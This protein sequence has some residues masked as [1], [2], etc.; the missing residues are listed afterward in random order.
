MNR[1][2][3]LVGVTAL[4]LLPCLAPADANSGSSRTAHAPQAYIDYCA[5]CHGD[6]AKGL[7]DLGADLVTSAFVKRQTDAELTDFMKMGRHPDSPDST[8]KLLMPAFDYLTDE[9][10]AQIVAFMRG[11]K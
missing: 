1:T 2:T 6:D 7:K 8:M 11:L 10:L 4:P 9:E 3:F 5:A